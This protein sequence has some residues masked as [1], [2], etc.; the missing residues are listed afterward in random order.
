M[1]HI[2]TTI[3]HRYITT[4][5]HLKLLSIIATVG[6]LFRV[7]KLQKTTF[8]HQACEQIDEQYLLGF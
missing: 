2:N 3:T 1:I 7:C 5:K 8:I 6:L 4:I